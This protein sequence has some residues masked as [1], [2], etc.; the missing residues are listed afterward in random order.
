MQHVINTG[1]QNLLEY[2][3]M[4]QQQLHVCCTGIAYALLK[5]LLAGWWATCSKSVGLKP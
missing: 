3:Q 4:R 1:E 5:I 2:V